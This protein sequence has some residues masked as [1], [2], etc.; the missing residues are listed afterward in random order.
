LAR[1][2]VGG[3]EPPKH[4]PTNTHPTQFHGRPSGIRTVCETR[5]SSGRSA[6]ELAFLHLNANGTYGKGE[7]RSGALG[8]RFYGPEFGGPYNFTMYVRHDKGEWAGDLVAGPASPWR[9]TYL[10]LFPKCQYQFQHA[11]IPLQIKMEGFA[12]WIPGDSKMSSLPVLFFDFQL[13]N[14]EATE[15]KV[16]LAFTIPNPESDGGTP[17][18]DKDGQIAGAVLPSRRAGGTLCGIVR[19]DGDARTTWGGDFT[20]GALN[21]AAGNRIASS[22]ALPAHAT[23][24]I[25]FV[26]AWDFPAGRCGSVPICPHRFR[27]GS[28]LFCPEQSLAAAWIIRAWNRIAIRNLC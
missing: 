5:F 17:V 21:G 25:V 24:H 10:P 18:R 22:L 11:A 2:A 12:P 9:V 3:R 14:P 4:Q 26:F 27:E 28:V 7:I 23:R 1:A 15:K 6:G 16:A 19:N 13:T 8:T 20:K